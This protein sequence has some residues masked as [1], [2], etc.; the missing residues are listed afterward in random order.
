M[1]FFNNLATFVIVN[2]QCCQICLQNRPLDTNSLWNKRNRIFKVE[3]QISK[4]A[5]FLTRQ[6]LC[7]NLIEKLTQGILHLIFISFKSLIFYICFRCVFAIF[8]T[9]VCHQKFELVRIDSC[10]DISN[11]ITTIFDTNFAQYNVRNKRISPRI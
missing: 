7:Y 1:A 8:R 6:I 9:L 11:K 2:I 10:E 5:L 4:K 3:Y